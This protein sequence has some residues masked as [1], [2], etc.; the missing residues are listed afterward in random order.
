MKRK[1]S[2]FDW[3]VTGAFWLMGLALA[4]SMLVIA[5]QQY[6]GQSD[7]APPLFVG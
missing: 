7:P 1:L 2:W 6:W 4:I 3:F 5:I